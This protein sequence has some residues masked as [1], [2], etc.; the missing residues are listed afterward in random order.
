MVL[1]NGNS[2]NVGTR[3]WSY[4]GICQRGSRQVSSQPVCDRKIH[5]TSRWWWGFIFHMCISGNSLAEVHSNI[6]LVLCLVFPSHVSF[7]GREAL[8]YPSRSAPLLSAGSVQTQSAIC[9]ASVVESPLR[10]NAIQRC[11]RW[12]EGSDRTDS[13]EPDKPPPGELWERICLIGKFVQLR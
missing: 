12:W 8:I 4:K 10:G 1:K 6:F 3:W 5:T 9:T 11:T 7:F 13:N 2:V